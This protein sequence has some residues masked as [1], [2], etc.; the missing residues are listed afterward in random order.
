MARTRFIAYE[1]NTDSATSDERLQVGHLRDT[2][3][4]L[5][6][7]LLSDVAEVP[8][9]EKALALIAESWPHARA[10]VL[11]FTARTKAEP[12]AKPKRAPRAKPASRQ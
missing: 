1:D 6:D 12:E 2:Y 11:G 7:E 3:N 8:E 9:R 5:A 4:V 10:A